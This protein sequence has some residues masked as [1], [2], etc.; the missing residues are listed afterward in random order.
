MYNVK[1]GCLERFVD[2][3]EASLV[4]GIQGLDSKKTFSAFYRV[5]EGERM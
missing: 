4:S 3:V 5:N 2:D 1:G